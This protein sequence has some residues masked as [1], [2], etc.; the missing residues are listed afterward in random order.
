MKHVRRPAFTLVELLI[1]IGIGAIL[2]GLLLP[3][4]QKVRESAARV[5]CANNLKQLSL[6]LHNF[7]GT[8][9]AFPPGYQAPGCDVGW[10]WGSFILPFIEQQALYAALGVGKQP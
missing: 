5:K 1:I 3:A 2:V 9:G 10:G 6:G 8:N 4:V 7:A